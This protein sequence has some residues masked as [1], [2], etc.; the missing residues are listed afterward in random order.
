MRGPARENSVQQVLQY[1]SS[2][3]KRVALRLGHLPQLAHS[4]QVRVPMGLGPVAQD[5]AGTVFNQHSAVRAP[6]LTS[7]R[8]PVENPKPLVP[9]GPHILRD[10]GATVKLVD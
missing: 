4:V 7:A 1:M 2:P 10:Q 6:E 9:K 3:L 5:L 8:Q